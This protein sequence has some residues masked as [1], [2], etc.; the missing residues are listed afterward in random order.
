MQEPEKRVSDP[1]APEVRSF[2]FDVRAEASENIAALETFQIATLPRAE[3]EDSILHVSPSIQESPDD[4]FAHRFGVVPRGTISL[5]PQVAEVLDRTLVHVLSEGLFDFDSAEPQGLSIRRGGSGVLSDGLAVRWV[6]FTE[7]QTQSWL[8]PDFNAVQAMVN[9]ESPDLEVD[10]QGVE[11]FAAAEARVLMVGEGDEIGLGV[12]V[13]A[14][15]RAEAI[16][17]FVRAI[18]G[19]GEPS[20]LYNALEQE[21]VRVLDGETT[22]GSK[23]YQDVLTWIRANLSWSVVCFDSSASYSNTAES[24]VLDLMMNDPESQDFLEAF[25]APALRCRVSFGNPQS[26]LVERPSFEWFHRNS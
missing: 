7:E 22:I 14:A 15:C 24:I 13:P 6:S 10:V 17:H 16:E 18:A 11:R 26:A 5:D 19:S 12:F 23:D 9:A 20:F 1:I 21:V 3:L 4:L 25:G 2:S 8:L